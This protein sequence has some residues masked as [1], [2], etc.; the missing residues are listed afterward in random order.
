[1]F[2]KDAKRGPLL[3]IGEKEALFLGKAQNTILRTILRNAKKGGKT[4]V[5]KCTL[6]F[7]A[8]FLI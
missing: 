2:I 4:N 1:M 5:A 7:K 6:H 3:L 8:Y